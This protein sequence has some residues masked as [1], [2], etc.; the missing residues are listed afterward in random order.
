MNP[1]PVETFF[2]LADKLKKHNAVDLITNVFDN[3]EQEY[4]DFLEALI[5]GDTDAMNEYMNEV[6]LQSFS[7]FDTGARSSKLQPE[8]FYHGFVLGLLVEL[9]GRFIVTSNRESGFGRY[10]ITLE[11]VD[12]NRDD[13]III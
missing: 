10:D 5:L 12:M 9:R 1:I 8:K 2:E 4:G 13:A 11:P 7:Y 3:V 6:S